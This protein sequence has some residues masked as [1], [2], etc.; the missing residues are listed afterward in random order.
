MRTT[1]TALAVVALTTGLIAGCSKSD[2]KSAGSSSSS[3]APLPDP[4][5]L[6]KQSAATTRGEPSVH[7]ELKVTKALQEK[8]PI[9]TLSGDLTNVPAVA[10]KGTAKVILGN[11]AVDRDFGGFNGDLY[12]PLVKGGKMQNFGPAKDIYDV[13]LILNPDQGLANVLSNF[14]DPKAAGR[15]S[16]NGVEAVKITGQVSKDAVN[17]IAPQLAVTDRVPGTAWIR[18]DGNHE[19]V[20]AQLDVSGGSITMTMSDWGK[21]VTVDQ[22]AP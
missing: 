8:L 20:Q 3:S 5:T 18:S 15:E 10:A 14:S 17:A 21:P 9:D 13:G 16:P 19:L 11:Q 4:A 22:P 6:L 1:A 7:L 12:V 2:D